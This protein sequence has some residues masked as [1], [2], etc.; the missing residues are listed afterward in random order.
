MKDL[1][2]KN[3][4]LTGGSRG[5]GPVIAEAL[6]AKG[7]NIALAARSEEEL[8]KVA[9]NLSSH[10]IRTVAIPADI[11]D[12]ASMQH[13]VEKTIDA[14]GTIDILVNNAGIE[15]VSRYVSLS[16]EQI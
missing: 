7:I 12:E 3:A 15:W 9:E 5:L 1:K 4:L 8:T 11:T 10:N 13:L 16:P 6:A 2:G 14:F